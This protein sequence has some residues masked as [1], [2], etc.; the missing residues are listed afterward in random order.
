[1]TSTDLENIIDELIN[2][3]KQKSIMKEESSIYKNPFNTELNIKE[4]KCFFKK[5]E[6]MRNY[7]IKTMMNYKNIKITK[8]HFIF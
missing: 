3:E 2:E 8:N 5:S 1:M 6:F 4:I 7:P